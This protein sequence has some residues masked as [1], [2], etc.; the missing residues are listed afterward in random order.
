MADQSSTPPGWYPDS[1][2]GQLR[3][4]DGTAWT[5]HTLRQLLRIPLPRSLPLQ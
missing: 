4:W 5:G 3:W 2:A 1:I